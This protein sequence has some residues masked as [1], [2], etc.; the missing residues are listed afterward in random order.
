MA[1]PVMHQIK[2][3]GR[4]LWCVEYAGMRRC[5]EQDWQAIWLHQLC[6]DLYL[7]DVEIDAS[8]DAM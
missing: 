8:R 6:L 7:A 3:N 1:K 4:L 5:Y 2:D